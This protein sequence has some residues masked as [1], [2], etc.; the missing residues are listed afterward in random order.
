M[1]SAAMVGRAIDVR[2]AEISPPAD[3]GRRGRFG[4]DRC[5][6]GEVGAGHRLAIVFGRAYTAVRDDYVF[7]AIRIERQLHLR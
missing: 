7:A 3:A 1:L 4:A 2:I 5:A 6:I